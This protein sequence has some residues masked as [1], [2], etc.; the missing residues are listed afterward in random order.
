MS[1][2]RVVI[3]QEIAAP[4]EQVFDWFYKSE[5]Y[6]TSPIV[7]QSKWHAG[8][9]WTSGSRRDIV[10]VVGWY[11]EEITDV[12]FNSYIR[13]RV[14]KSFPAVKQDFTEIAFEELGKNQTKL[15]WTIELKV[16]LPVIGPVMTQL[17]G[18]MAKLLY[19][20]IMIA[21]KKELED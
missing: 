15:V 8:S 6:I 7:F 9:K 19:K 12:K 18:Q 4:I 20:T 5:N 2:Q 21:G 3:S 1:I 16:P 11:S 14:N 13:Y 10:M 17:G